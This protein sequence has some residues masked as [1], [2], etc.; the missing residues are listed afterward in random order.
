MANPQYLVR[1]IYL[2]RMS[3][4]LLAVVLTTFLRGSELLAEPLSILTLMLLV[5]YPFA[6]YRLSQ[7]FFNSS[8][9]ARWSMSIDSLLVGILIILNEF[10][11][12]AAATYMTFLAVSTA[13][14][15][16]PVMVLLNLSIV[17]FVAATAWWLG[18]PARIEVEV[19][20]D[21]GFALAILVYTGYV[22]W[23]VFGVT[24]AM[25]IARRDERSVRLSL[26]QMTLHLK[27]YISPQLF[28]TLASASGTQATS[29]RQLTVCFTDLTGF[30]ALMDN[31]PEEAIT[32]VL[33][34][35]L[36]AMADIAIRHGG[37]V[38]K[39]M[40]DGVMVFFGD[41]QS[42]G[43]REDAVS[44]VK[45]ALEMRGCLAGLSRRWRDEGLLN[46]LQIRVGI[47]TGYCAVGNFGSENRMDY[48]V[49]GGAVNIASRLEGCAPPDGIL[50]SESTQALIRE[51]ISLESFERQQLRGIKKP[52]DTYRVI[53]VRRHRALADLNEQVPG[54]HLH[55]SSKEVDISAAKAL[56]ERGLKQLTNIEALSQSRQHVIRLLR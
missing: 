2:P 43:P 48:T 46:R 12:M 51:V 20:V 50:I 47:H 31:L 21:I 35:Y 42:R 19:W 45:M 56:L 37:T 11:L 28:S 53:G 44:C 38:D 16:G 27:R 36:N 3:G 4:F 41:P 23:L 54:L 15:A 10:Y 55:L 34:E 32:R 6:A 7:R 29:R 49:V 22:S 30:T 25:G 18:A 52:V 24:Q 9:A 1:T 5:V 8:S 17:A 40:G 13:V 33:N 26:E 39:F 14:I